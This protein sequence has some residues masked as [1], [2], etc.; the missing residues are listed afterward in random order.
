MECGVVFTC[1]K[2]PHPSSHA[3]F[4]GARGSGLVRACTHCYL[5]CSTKEEL[6]L[7]AVVLVVGVYGVVPLES[8]EAFCPLCGGAESSEIEVELGHAKDVCEGFVKCW[9]DLLMFVVVWAYW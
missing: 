3:G 6:V 1:K 9:D 8:L 7:T 2:G 4:I 5:S